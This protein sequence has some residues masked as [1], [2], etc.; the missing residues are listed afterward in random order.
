MPNIC[1]WLVWKEAR[2]LYRVSAHLFFF[3]NAHPR[4][5]IFFN[6][7]LN[8]T[9]VGNLSIWNLYKH[10][11]P[12]SELRESAQM[13]RRFPLLVKVRNRYSMQKQTKKSNIFLKFCNKTGKNIVH[14]FY[15]KGRKY[16]SG[17]SAIKRLALFD[18]P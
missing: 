18:P 5:L 13:F 11:Y 3:S 16:S 14:Y 6:K 12:F 10:I 4:F 8:I 15:T 9:D 2:Y 7:T 1:Q 17:H